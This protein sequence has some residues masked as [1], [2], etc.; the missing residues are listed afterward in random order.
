MEPVDIEWAHDL[1]KT[2]QTFLLF[3]LLGWLSVDDNEATRN[4]LQE[5]LDNFLRC[6]LANS[7]EKDA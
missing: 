5:G 7:G 4:S 3:Y 1:T 2:Q 6:Y